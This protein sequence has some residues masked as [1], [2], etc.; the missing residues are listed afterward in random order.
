MKV[1]RLIEWSGVA[2]LF[3]VLTACAQSVAS[4]AATLP[5]ESAAPMPTAAASPRLQ[6]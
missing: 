5:T 4:P 2:V 6:P 3:M 1:R